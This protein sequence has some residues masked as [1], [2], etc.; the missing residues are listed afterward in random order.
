MEM[1]R[2]ATVR[3]VIED[4]SQVAE[5]RRIARTNAHEVGFDANRAEQVAIV[6]TE[7][8]TNLLKHAERG[9]ILL[10]PIAASNG[11]AHPVLELL[12]L[13]R[14]PGIGNVNQ[15][16]EDGYSTAGS[17]GEGLGA[18]LRLSTFSDIY[19]RP[20]S[21]TALL[22]RWVA[23]PEGSSRPHRLAIGAVNVCKPGQIV[24]GDAWGSVEK[25]GYTTVVVADGLGHGLE[26]SVASQDALRMLREEPALQP[27]DLLERIHQ[28]LRSTRG[29]AV[30][31]A[32]IDRERGKLTFSG[33]G[34]IA[35]R[36]Y[37]GS[38][39]AQHLV[40]V[41]GTAGHQIH[42]LREF[43]YPWPANG[44]LILHSDG[45]TSG[46]G[47]DA[48]PG[49]ALRDPSLLAG[50]LYRDYKRGNDDATV[51]VVRENSERGEP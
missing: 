32:R 36:I 7:V 44:I 2:S 38:T 26:A 1:M 17:K 27:I 33:A 22:A 48:L 6:T 3:I 19:S 8:A 35:A 45:L 31:V 39:P 16:L 47:L 49:S 4:P 51:V 13:D 11:D 30:A 28:A 41:N 34:N 25:D 21:G 37:A 46:T 24:C 29:A 50:L 10:N 12:A 42:Q 20:G 9:E 40:S 43:S 18:V 5:A 23:G 15:C 14:G